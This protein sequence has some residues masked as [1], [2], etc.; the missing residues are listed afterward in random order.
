MS[1][2]HL[3]R[4]RSRRV[5]I[6][7][8]PLIDV[9]FLLLIFFMVTSTFAKN[10]GLEITLP[11]ITKGVNFMRKEMFEIAVT[12]EKKVFVNSEEVNVENLSAIVKKVKEEKPEVQIFLKADTDVAYGFIVQVMNQLR[13]GGIKNVAAI[14]E[15]NKEDQ[16]SKS[17][18]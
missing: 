11:K 9:L 12:K 3:F 14:T 5:Q 16:K 2:L 7:I 10:P 6:N 4:R 8:T 17:K 13:L 18:E 15:E 1:D